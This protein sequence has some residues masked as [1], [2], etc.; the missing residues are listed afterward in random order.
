QPTASGAS[1]LSVVLVAL[2]AKRLR[3]EAGRRVRLQREALVDVDEVRLQLDVEVRRE[4]RLH[5][6]AE[7]VLREH[8]RTLDPRMEADAFRVQAAALEG[9]Q[10]KR[11]GFLFL[12]RRDEVAD[13]VGAAQRVDRVLRA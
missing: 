2:A 12:V 6:D 10:A 3:A 7:R 11:A 1:D 4:L 13:G 9:R 5:V 8:V